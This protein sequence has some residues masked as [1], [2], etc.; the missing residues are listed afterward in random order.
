MK[1][2]FG[3]MYT[4]CLLVALSVCMS[5]CA[6]SS[7]RASVNEGSAVAELAADTAPEAVL[8]KIGTNRNRALIVQAD[9]TAMT[10]Y[11][12][13]KSNGKWRPAFES[14]GF[15]G[16]GGVG[17]NKK[18]GDGKTPTGVFTINRAFGIK[19]NPGSNLPYTKVGKDD[20]WVDDPASVHYNTWAKGSVPNRDWKSAEHLIT[21]TRAYAYAAVIEYNTNPIVKG[22]GSAIF[23]HCSKGRPTAGCVSVP[24]ADMVRLL[25]FL[26]PGDIIAIMDSN[27]P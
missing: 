23:L 13:E 19:N 22:A 7:E 16:K 26:Q 4:A 24:E 5:G 10:L 3:A 21:E 11:A 14:K 12:Y 17:R 20:Y 15:V 18:E 1:K 25:K 6:A 9:G 2:R 8:Q 27:K